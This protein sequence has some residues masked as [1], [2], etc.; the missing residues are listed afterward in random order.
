MLHVAVAVAYLWCYVAA[1]AAVYY[2]LASLILSRYSFSKRRKAVAQLALNESTVLLCFVYLMR[3]IIYYC[4]YM[5]FYIL[6]HF[7]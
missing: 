3:S 6:N 7:S 4:I 1:C 5:I 2:H